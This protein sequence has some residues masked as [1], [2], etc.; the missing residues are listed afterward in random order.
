MIKQLVKCTQC[1][2][3]GS[4][5]DLVLV[6]EGDEEDGEWIKACPNCKTDHNLMDTD[7][8]LVPEDDW[9]MKEIMSNKNY[10]KIKLRGEI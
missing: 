8:I 1:E 6:W 4:E 2:W 7:M 5:D 9:E 3:T 10:K